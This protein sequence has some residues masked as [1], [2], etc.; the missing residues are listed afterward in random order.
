I[1]EA[2]GLPKKTDEEKAARTQAIQDATK[3]AIEIPYRTLF[4][5]FEVFEFCQKMVEI[6]NPNSVTDA[7]V[8]IL[9]AR[10][11]CIGAFMNMQ[12]NCASL[13]DKEFVKDILDKGRNIIARADEIEREYK[14]R[15]LKQINE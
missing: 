14:A 12:I 15:V 5:S 7:A 6:G 10:A 11:A 1:M 13:N 4:K 8:G 9:C 2:F 3:Y